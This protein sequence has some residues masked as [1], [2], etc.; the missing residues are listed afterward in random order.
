MRTSLAWQRDLV[1]ALVDDPS[2]L[3][4]GPASRIETH[5]SWVILT[6]RYAFKLKKALAEP[7][8]HHDT[9]RDRRLACQSEVHLNRRLAA[10]VYLGVIGLCGTADGTVHRRENDTV[11]ADEYLV[12]MKRLDERRNLYHQI[13]QGR[14]DPADL[15]A[16]VDALAAFYRRSPPEWLSPYGHWR[17]MQHQ[18]SE[19]VRELAAHAL[20]P[21]GGSLADLEEAL[22]RLG[23]ELRQLI[24]ER[25]RTGR[26]REVHG[27]LRPEHVYFAGEPVI[28][29]CLEF[30]RALRLQDPVEEIAFLAME[31]ERMGAIEAA[32]RL[33]RRFGKATGE[34]PPAGLWHFYAARRALLWAVLAIRHRHHADARGEND[35]SDRAR[36]YLALVEGHL[37]CLGPDRAVR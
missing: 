33:Q 35:W 11:E 18:I 2:A 15:D 10:D 14:V 13:R 22:Q 5:F 20:Q 31:C 36:G 3:E 26:I 32:H 7:W 6:P 19:H 9:P 28:I 37:D 34:R 30:S 24:E 4:D 17:H 21:A 12:Q 25:I 29:D 16:L 27:D 1:R 8:L 23:R